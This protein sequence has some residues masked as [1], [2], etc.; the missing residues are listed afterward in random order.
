MQWS[1][2]SKWIWMQQE[3]QKDS[4]GEFVS[5]FVY[6][7]GSVS[8]KISVDSNYVV[9]VNGRYAASE[10]YPDFPHYKVYDEIDITRLCSMG[11]NRI[12]V[13]AW[14]YGEVFMT[15]YMGKAALRFEVCSDGKVLT[16]SDERTFSRVSHAYQSGLGHVLTPQLGFGYCYDATKED[17][18]IINTE[19]DF[20]GSF[21][22]EQDPP[23]VKRSIRK[24]VIGERARTEPVKQEENYDL[25]DIGYEEVGYLTFKV[26]SD[27][28]QKIKVCYGEHI[29][30]GVVRS[31]LPWR[32]FSFEIVI[33][34]G[35]TEY[36]NYMRRLGCRY[37]EL[38]SEKPL[39]IEFLSV[40]PCTYPFKKK[41]RV[42]Q[43]SLHQ[44]I[45]DVSVRTLELC[46]HDH[47]EDCPWR[48]QGLYAMDSRNQ[49]L[50]GYYAF[51]EYAAPRDNLY[52]MSKVDREDNLLSICIPTNFDYAIPSFSLHYVT[53]IYE[54]C[55]HSGDLSLAKEVLPKL[56][57]MMQ[58]FTD[59]IKDGLITNFVTTKSPGYWNFYEWKEGL[60]GYA[61]EDKSLRYDAALN[62]LLSIALQKMQKI[63][64]L[65]AVEASYGKMADALNEQ[66]NK[67][68]YNDENG[69]Y[70][71]H[72]GSGDCSELVNSL[73]VLCGAAKGKA[74]E[75]ICAV[76]AGEND[77]T[78]VSLSMACFKYDALLSVDEKMYAPYVI[79]TLEKVYKRMLDAGATS[80]WEDEEG[81]E[82]FDKA[83]SLCHG[84]SAMPV[85]YF[86]RLSEYVD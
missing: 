10:Q 25:Y 84:W 59:R 81:A 9:F 65:L 61:P 55:I 69:L 78:G 22:V 57:A 85:Y 33:G 12:A 38:H 50:C 32:D 3:A 1:T 80:F 18:W 62:C 2:D 44:K 6:T 58:T 51:D 34:E 76:L 60:N 45:Y 16:V 63:C 83:G 67:A 47:Y 54:Y 21:V 19:A 36:T 40:L 43:N 27:C 70:A 8:V 13:L 31:V 68:F 23:L 5:D 4:Y 30:D 73:A 86:H 64:D 66:I 77:L 15:Y 11:E 75:R 29:E 37:L 82:A 46:L 42:F 39:E 53:E 35:V 71:N 74:A 20:S 28:K 48:E 52:L 26:K 17:D 7:G 41:K 79:Q 72:P 24:C 56:T 49:I 14:Y